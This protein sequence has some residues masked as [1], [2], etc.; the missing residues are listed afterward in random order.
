MPSPA[1]PAR[2]TAPHWAW[3]PERTPRWRVRPRLGGASSPPKRTDEAGTW[4]GFCGRASEEI[5]VSRRY[6]HV[7]ARPGGGPLHPH[8]G[9]RSPFPGCAIRPRAL[10]QGPDASAREFADT[11]LR[12]P[13]A[14]RVVHST[15]WR[16]ERGRIVLSYLVY[17][18][19]L[20]FR[21]RSRRV[22]F[23]ALPSPEAPAK[24]ARDR[25]RAVASHALRHLAFLGAQDPREYAA[26][27]SPETRRALRQLRPAAAGRVRHRS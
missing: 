3:L 9:S 7:S 19:R 24:D 13:D 11:R 15:S 27:L 6:F 16:Y 22:R 12:V 14:L 26:K 1:P 8:R 23:D 4:S 25:D 17:S 21:G 20:M 5:R 2:M 10:P 18:D